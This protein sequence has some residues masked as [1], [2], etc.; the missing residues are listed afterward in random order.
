MSLIRGD[1]ARIAMPHSRR[2]RPTE[3]CASTHIVNPN[4]AIHICLKKVWELA[5]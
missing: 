2:I 1:T 5:E 3:D 4:E